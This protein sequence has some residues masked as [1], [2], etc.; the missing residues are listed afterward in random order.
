MKKGV[1][2]EAGPLGSDPVYR[3]SAVA[4]DDVVYKLGGD[5]GG[6]YPTGRAAV[7]MECSSFPWVMF[8]PAIT[9]SGN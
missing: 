4:L 9:G 7:Y 8:L 2:L 5:M 1:W 3:T 6:F